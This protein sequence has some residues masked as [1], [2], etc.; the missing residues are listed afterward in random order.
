MYNEFYGFSEE[1]FELAPDPKFLYLS[2]SHQDALVTLFNGMED[3]KGFI[4]LTGET[5]T[6]KKTLLHFLLGR[7]DHKLKPVFVVHPPATFEDL[8]REISVGLSLKVSG[9][10]R[11]ALLNQLNEYLQNLAEDE[12][13]VVIIDEG[14]TLPKTVMEE[15]ARLREMIPQTS[16]RLQ[17]LFIGL[18]EFEAR[19]NSSDLSQINEKIGTRCQI[20]TLTEE[21]SRRYIDHR[22]KR[23]GSSGSEAF[24]PN[25]ISTILIHAKGIPRVINLLCGRAFQ[26][27][28][29]SSRRRIDAEIVGEVINEMQNPAPQKS[30][31]V[32]IV[33]SLG[34]SS[35]RLL[36]MNLSPRRISFAIV[37]FLCVGSLFLLIHGSLQTKPTKTGKIES[38]KKSRKEAM[39]E[40]VTVEEGESISSLCQKYYHTMNPT[41]LDLILEFNPEITDA[42]FIQVK[43]KIKIPKITKDWLIS[44]SL[45]R[46]YKIHV[47]TFWTSDFV[48]SYAREPAL[49]GKKIEAVPRKVSPQ[50]TWYRVIVG[51]FDNKDEALRTIDLLKEK[52]LLPLF[53]DNPKKE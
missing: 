5:G 17:I 40:V 14:Q 42:A 12:V 8:L 6:G 28:Y 52:K 43:Q 2:P 35:L 16:N 41:L 1:P 33:P 37:S 32:N 3:R 22:L 38:L 51:N 4:S 29:E 23:V 20:K 53:G 31:S 11:Q 24:T 47:G 44:Q 10:D 21:E 50:A 25:A 34:K 7:L 26:V 39:M 36:R 30:I 19:L 18:P 9:E 27:G 13:L 46:A 48:K 15:L 45:D 49:K